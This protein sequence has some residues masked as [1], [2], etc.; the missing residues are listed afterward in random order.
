M[1]THHEV[2]VRDVFREYIEAKREFLAVT[3]RCSLKGW[4]DR[5]SVLEDFSKMCAFVIEQEVLRFDY[6]LSGVPV[7]AAVWKSLEGIL[8]R[9]SKDWKDSD[10]SGL[11]AKSAAYRDVSKQLAAAE[12]I[13]DKAALDGPFKGTQGDP[14]WK[15]A[16]RV[17]ND[18]RSELDKRLARLRLS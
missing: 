3:D 10:E 8:N 9:I 11:A 1:R 18:K 15:N 16:V 5:K 6:M 2:E 12:A 13:V 17:F 4:P 7:E 14:E